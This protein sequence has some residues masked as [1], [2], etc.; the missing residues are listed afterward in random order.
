MPLPYQVIILHDDLMPLW[1][2]NNSMISIFN[3]L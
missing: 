2:K 3:E 1:T